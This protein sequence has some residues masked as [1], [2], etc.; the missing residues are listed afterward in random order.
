MAFVT[1]P[2]VPTEIRWSADQ[3]QPQAVQFDGEDYEVEAV[4]SVRDE[5]AAWPA[6][7][8]PRLTLVL[9][10][11]N[12]QR[13][14]VFWDP[15]RSHGPLMDGISPPDR[16]TSRAG[17]YPPADPARQPLRLGDPAYNL[18]VTQPNSLLDQ[19]TS[20]LTARLASAD[21]TP[22]GGS[23]AALGGAVA[24][25]L[26]EMVARLSLGR[27]ELAD[28]EPLFRQVAEAAAGRPTC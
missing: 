14:E 3:P 15:G 12:G 18:G 23:A 28:A 26:V 19:P 2:P 27:A 25:A 22:G 16:L 20:E 1:F 9:A 7:R 24:A 21:P 10:T 6:E 13:A 5:R 8:G 11:T 4:I 17:A